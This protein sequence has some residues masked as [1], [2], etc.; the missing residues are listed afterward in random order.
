MIEIMIVDDQPLVVEGLKMI[1][2]SFDDINVIATA[3][4]GQDACD[5]MN[6]YKPDVILMDI[7][8]PIMNGVDATS[9][10]KSEHPNVKIIILNIIGSLI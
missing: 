8:M 4:N 1:L 9:K 5:N 6:L 2:N 3:G 10:I 7:K